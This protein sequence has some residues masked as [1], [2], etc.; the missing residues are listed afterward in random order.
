LVHFFVR[1]LPHLLNIRCCLYY[2]FILLIW[3][4]IIRCIYASFIF[5][6]FIMF[7]LIV[8]VC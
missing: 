7:M 2:S 1:L 5:G 6:Q 4:C 8:W 3:R